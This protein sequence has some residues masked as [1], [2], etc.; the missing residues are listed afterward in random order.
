MDSVVVILSI[1]SVFS[2]SLIVFLIYDRRTRDESSK[3]GDELERTIT[4]SIESIYEK[5][6]KDFK[7][8]SKENF[9]NVIDP[10]KKRIKEFEE[11]VRKNTTQQ[12]EF[13][14]KTKLTIDNLIEQTNQITSDANKL[15]KALS[16]ESKT[17][18]D[19]GEFKLQMLLENSGLE[20]NIHY[21]LQKS[22]TVKIEGDISKE[23]PDAVIYLP[24]NRNIIIDS[25]FSFTAYND[26]CNTD[27]KEERVKHGKSLTKNIRERIND[28]SSTK[29]S[30][31]EELNTPDIIFMFLGI[32]DSLSVAL[33]YD[34]ELVSYADKKRIALVSPSIL[35]ISIKMVENLWRL[36]GQRESVVKVYE[37]AQKLVDKLHGFTN[38]MDSLGTS[39]AQSQKKYDDARNKLID[40]KGSMSSKIEGL[41][42]L[43]SKE[44]KKL[45]ND[46]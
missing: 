42:A 19:Y 13:H 46:D 5:K 36:D 11:E 33:K 43:G 7:K 14:T 6:E 9:E 2:L 25:K 31:I 27:V 41:V 20:E 28:L 39:I 44:T 3:L 15:T 4:S 10:F 35:H 1:F 12:H 16:G 40:G 30:Q 37:E 18:G 23:I 45:T 24:Q 38:V 34:P 8:A 26:Y 29:Y 22:F 32:D 21:K 17:Q